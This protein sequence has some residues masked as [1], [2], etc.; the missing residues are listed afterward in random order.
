M[1]IRRGR[2]RRGV[3]DSWA[4]AHRLSAPDGF[5][6]VAAGGTSDTVRERQIERV[7][8]HIERFDRIRATSAS[9]AGVV[10]SA[11]ALLSAG[12]AVALAQVLSS[13]RAGLRWLEIGGGIIGCANLAILVGCVVVSSGVLISTRKTGALY[14]GDSMPNSLF[15]N[16]S[17]TLREFSE[18]QMFRDALLTSESEYD[19]AA[20]ELWRNMRQHRRRYAMLRRAVRLMRIA[21]FG[22]LLLACTG[23][24]LRVM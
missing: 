23:V 1:R 10:L 9:R 15:Y 8:W 6:E 16:D 7:Q 22:F 13:S 24:L 2:P 4:P 21:A 19:Y 14:A 20:S 17:D 12:N 5:A 3:A 11:A 18:F